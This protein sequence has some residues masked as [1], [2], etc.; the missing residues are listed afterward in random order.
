M[1]DGRLLF[2]IAQADVAAEGTVPGD[3]DAKE[4]GGC[5]PNGVKRLVE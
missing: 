1:E 2:Q 3:I 5:Q 4:S